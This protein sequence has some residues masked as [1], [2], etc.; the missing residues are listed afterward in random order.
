MADLLMKMPGTYEPKKKNRWLLSQF[1]LSYYFF[2]VKDIELEVADYI[3][4]D[5]DLAVTACR[6]SPLVGQRRL[7]LPHG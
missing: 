1:Y 2:S 3:E 4:F 5:I 7:P 6:N